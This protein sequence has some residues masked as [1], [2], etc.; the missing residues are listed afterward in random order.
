MEAGTRRIEGGAFNPPSYLSS[1]HNL[2]SSHPQ[3]HGATEGVGAPSH[4]NAL[5]LSFPFCVWEA[6]LK[7]IKHSFLKTAIP[8]L[9]HAW[10]VCFLGPVKWGKEKESEGAPIHMVPTRSGPHEMPHPM[11]L[12]LAAVP[13]IY[14]SHL[15]SCSLTLKDFSLPDLDYPLGTIGTCLGAPKLSPILP[16]P[17][18][19]H[20][21][22]LLYLLISFL[23]GLSGFHF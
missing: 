12:R 16:A 22:W 13:Y 1:L 6:N 5:S 15:P 10:K 17:F 3:T 9:H 23:A 4:L 7:T 11:D 18:C 19:L 8:L 2:H 20:C 21:K 14:R